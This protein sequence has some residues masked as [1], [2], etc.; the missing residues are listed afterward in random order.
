M[1]AVAQLAV[2]LAEVTRK[3]EQQRFLEALRIIRETKIL[4]IANIYLSSIEQFVSR[5]QTEFG[6]FTLQILQRLIHLANDDCIQR[7][8]MQTEAEAVLYRQTTALEKIKNRY[9]EFADEFFELKHYQRALEELQRVYLI[10]ADNVVAKHYEQKIQQLLSL[11][12]E[13]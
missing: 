9:F 6:E 13:E 12:S 4:D 3:V 2:N 8:N 7:S 10:D 1:E 5:L 11:K